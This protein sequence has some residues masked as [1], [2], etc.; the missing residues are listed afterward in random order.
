MPMALAAT[1][2]RV[3]SNVAI[4]PLKPWLLFSFG[5]SALPRMSLA[6]Q[7]RQLA[8]LGLV[9]DTQTLWDQLHAL[10]GHLT[11]TSEALLAYR[12]P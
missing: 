9:T 2:G 5:I 10:S 7:V 4:T 1:A 8:R 12:C 11:P 3:A 6:R